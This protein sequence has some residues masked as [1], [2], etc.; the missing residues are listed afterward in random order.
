[1]SFR[2]KYAK[3][4]I[5]YLF[6]LLPSAIKKFAGWCVDVWMHLEWAR[7]QTAW[8]FIKNFRYTSYTPPQDKA[9]LRAYQPVVSLHNSLLNPCFWGDSVVGLSVFKST[10]RAAKKKHGFGG[11]PTPCE[12]SK[13]VDFFMFCGCFLRSWTKNQTAWLSENWIRGMAGFPANPPNGWLKTR[14]PKNIGDVSFP[15][16]PQGSG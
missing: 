13:G 10:C 12:I 8:S 11:T 15:A 9:L 7:I 6:S 14:F 5:M 3:T 16:F 2:G 4:V 1:M